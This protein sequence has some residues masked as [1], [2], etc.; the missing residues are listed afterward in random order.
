MM[1]IIVIIITRV[2]N[3]SPLSTSKRAYMLT[4]NSNQFI[5]LTY[6]ARITRETS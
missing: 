1:M 2:K 6:A 5:K 3:N 4:N